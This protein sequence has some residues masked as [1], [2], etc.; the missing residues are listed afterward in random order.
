[1]LWEPR[2][3]IRAGYYL[4]RGITKKHKFLVGEQSLDVGREGRDRAIAIEGDVTVS[5][6]MILAS[7]YCEREAAWLQAYRKPLVRRAALDS[8]RNVSF[9]CIGH[10]S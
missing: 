7:E 4:R 6:Q 3:E 5:E 2:S 8:V 9:D 10:E 1:M